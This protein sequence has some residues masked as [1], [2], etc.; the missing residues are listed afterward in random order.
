MGPQLPSFGGGKSRSGG[1]LC[2]DMGRQ[3]ISGG[4]NPQGSQS[5][6]VGFGIRRHVGCVA[7]RSAC[8]VD[9]STPKAD[10]AAGRRGHWLSVVAGEPRL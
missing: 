7:D 4:A 9:K 1:G 3:E 8:E 5:A 10:G 2:H 6:V